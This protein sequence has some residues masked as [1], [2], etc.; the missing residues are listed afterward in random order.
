M[1]HALI[2]L[3]AA[4]GGSQIAE[5]HPTDTTKFLPA[6]LE[7]TRPHEGDPRTVKVRVWADTAVR[8]L[9]HWKED[10]TDQID[11]ASQVLTPLLGARLSIDEFRDWT[12]TAE[13]SGA[14]EELAAADKGDGVTWV[15]GYIAPGDAASKAMPELGDAHVL[16]HHVIVRAWASAPETEAIAQTLPDLKQNERA[17]LIAAHERHK[18]TVVLLHMLAITLGAIGEADPAWIQHPLY[19]PKQSTFS[20]RNRE[21]M[22]IAI[23]KRFAQQPDVA[24]AHDLLESI[25]KTDWG[26]WIGPDKDQVVT[27]LRATVDATRAGQTATDVPA[28]AYA[29]FDRIRELRKRHDIT[30]ALAE[31]DNLLAAYPANGTIHQL[32]CDILL[33]V[34]AA[35][36]APPAPPKGAPPGPPPPKLAPRADREKAAKAACARAIELSP[37]DPMPHFAIAEAM[38]RAGD[39]TAAR[40]ELVAAA[41]KI[42]NLKTGQPEAWKRLAGTYMAIGALTWTE[43]ALEA[44]KLDQDPLAAQVAQIR[45][46]YGVPHGY[47]VKPEQE[48]ALVTAARGAIQAVGTG[49]FTAAEQL[50]GAAEKKWPGAP[51]LATARCDMY[52]RQ[53][54]IDAARSACAKALASDPNESWALYLSGVL[55]LRDT[56]ASGTTAGVDKLK[57]AIAIDPDLG[58]AWRAL[59]KAYSRVKD[60][61]ALAALDQA[62]TA[63]FGQPLPQ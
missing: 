6:T 4:C 46:R 47:K 42:G 14:L 30:T 60:K 52:F 62:Y 26:G 9:P 43:E 22:Q 11:Y 25:E 63:K 24:I 37:G 54:Q 29:Q 12:R 44:G 28:S 3:L 57:R 27:L 34:A 2:A 19:S 55:A 41:G 31:L 38:L 1:R 61:A 17:E 39:I 35:P 40:A 51:G 13:P 16:G 15:I 58:Q 36:D 20:D 33:E 18:Q 45:A 48:G 56:S 59:A 23:D 50:I 7:A 5:H 53:N 8:A 21:L 32:K 49:Q 10:I